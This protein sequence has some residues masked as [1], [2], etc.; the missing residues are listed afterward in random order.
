[1]DVVQ[2]TAL[3]D[4]PLLKFISSVARAFTVAELNRR[5]WLRLVAL[6]PETPFPLRLGPGQRLVQNILYS[7][8]AGI[9]MRARFEPR[10]Y[11]RT[12]MVTGTIWRNVSLCLNSGVKGPAQG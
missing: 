9:E 12:S 10:R 8:T 11:G 4:D 6:T 1:M 5:R 2:F 7:S 3:A